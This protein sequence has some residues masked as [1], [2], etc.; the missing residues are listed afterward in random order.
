MR[1]K[2]IIYRIIF[3]L[4]VIFLILGFAMRFSKNQ[5]MQVIF[6]DV[7]QGDAILISQ[8]SSQVL[9]D[10]GRSGQVILEKLGRYVPFWDR[11]IETVLMTHPDQDHIGGFAD[12]FAS[13]EIKTVIKTDVKSDSQTFKV[14]EEHIEK[15]KS[16]IVEG[17]N[18]VK[19]IFPDQKEMEIIYPFSSVSEN[20]KDTNGSSIVSVLKFGESKFLLTG[21]LTSE[22]ED[23]ILRKGIA[24]SADVLKVGHHGSKYSTSAQFLEKVSPRDAV[25]S[26]GKNSYGHPT[27][28]ILERLKKQGVSISRTDEKGDIIYDCLFSQNQCRQR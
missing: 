21:D 25:I 18:G 22:K 24:V 9:I 19:I 15:E 7:G 23:K 10:S 13:Y 1:N 17:K 11:K 5:D 6:F 8:G 12:V 4:L 20:A 27:M 3:S 2:K 28:E 26:V 14:L 16:E